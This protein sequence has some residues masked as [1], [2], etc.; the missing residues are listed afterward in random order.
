[1]TADEEQELE[2]GRDLSQREE[3]VLP[4]AGLSSGL[5]QF[6]FITGCIVLFVLVSKLYLDQY[7]EIRELDQQLDR[8]RA[9]VEDAERE[10][11]RLAAELR[12]LR[13]PDGTEKIAR[14]KLKMVR[15]DEVIIVPVEP[16]RL[17][18]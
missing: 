16:G 9:R 13:T 2:A 3:D 4:V 17:T 15:P 5:F 8:E 1:M 18:R 14:E 12:F 10:K 7:L 11:D 6:L